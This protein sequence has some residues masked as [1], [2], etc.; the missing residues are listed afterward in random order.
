L[1]GLGGKQFGHLW[2]AVWEE[3]PGKDQHVDVVGGA[4]Q[5]ASPQRSW[6]GAAVG[7]RVTSSAALAAWMRRSSAISG[8]R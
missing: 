6:H 8:H 2:V 5:Q 7:V 4:I 3:Q 1:L